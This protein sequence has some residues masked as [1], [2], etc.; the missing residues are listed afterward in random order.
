MAHS[1]RLIAMD[2][3]EHQVFLNVPFDSRYKKLLRALVFAVHSCGFNARCALEVT[4]GGEVRVDKIFRIIESCRFGIHDLSRTSPDA[5][6]RLPRFNMPLELGIFLGARR[7]GDK[8]NRRKACL[9][10]DREK[11]RYQ[12]SCSDIAGQ[13]IVAHGNEAKQALIGVRDWLQTH[14]STS[15]RLPGPKRI[16][17]DYAEFQRLLPRIC[18]ADDLSERDLT[19]IDYR[20]V[21]AGWIEVA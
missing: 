13:D 6:H 20:N 11:Y 12:I 7:F 17:E 3:Y 14:V 21:V 1:P 19:F 15:R 10:L 9:I 4:D 8:I 5:R 16:M 2:P 18:A